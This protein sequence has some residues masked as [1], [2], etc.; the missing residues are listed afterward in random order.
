MIAPTMGFCLYMKY[1]FEKGGDFGMA[2]EQNLRPSEHKLTED[3]VK[4]GGKK[5]GEVRSLRSTVR[6]QLGLK[7]PKKGMSDVH[8][9]M[10]EMGIPKGSRT[11]NEAITAAIL[12]KAAK[13]NIAAAKYIHE[14][15]G[16]KPSE[17]VEVEMGPATRDALADMSLED[18]LALRDELLMKLGGS[19]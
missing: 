10:D 11:Y 8:E 2:N 4:K 3:E 13:G 15:I 6:K 1:L 19:E 14:I 18:R 7:I 17:K 16:E 12:H 5:S 9:L